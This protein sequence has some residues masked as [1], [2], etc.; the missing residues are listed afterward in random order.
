MYTPNLHIKKA[1]TPEKTMGYGFSSLEKILFY[2]KL[3]LVIKTKKAII[4]IKLF[5]LHSSIRGNIKSSQKN[6]TPPLYEKWG[7]CIQIMSPLWL[8][9]AYYCKSRKYTANNTVF[10]QGYSLIHLIAKMILS[11]TERKKLVDILISICIV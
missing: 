11:N 8:G 3:T 9:L 7:L 10:S 2:N 1:V 6:K 5:I 4:K